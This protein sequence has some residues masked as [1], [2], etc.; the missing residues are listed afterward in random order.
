ML[1]LNNVT[2]SEGM[3]D[4]ALMPD[5]VVAR[6]IVKLSGGDIELPE[7]GGGAYFK[8]SQSGAKWMPIEVTIVG[9]DFDKRK[10]W[11]NIFVDGAKLDANG[12]PVAKRIGLETIK[13]MVN[14][15]FGLTENDNSPEALQ[16]RASINGVH[17][18][19]GMEICFKIG[20]EKGNNGYADKNKIKVVLTPAD[21]EFIPS[22]GN[23]PTAA[24]QA[25]APA[26]PVQQQA[27]APSAAPNNGV[28][29]P[30]AR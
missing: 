13:R 5:G 17:V 1:D 11:Q 28:T 14:S 29:P 2:Y 23:A 25:Q 22:S 3:G 24:P 8:S 26:A 4:L 15:A 20:I 12:F 27:A 6:G 21:K 16:K 19:N 9:G 10:V 30:W 7:F 18:L